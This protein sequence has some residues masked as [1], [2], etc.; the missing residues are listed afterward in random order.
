MTTKKK[1]KNG[2]EKNSVKEKSSSKKN[3]NNNSLKG[4]AEMSNKKENNKVENGVTEGKNQNALREG[5]TP[6][7][8]D[9]EHMHLKYIQ[10]S[11]DMV[12]VYLA[13]SDDK[14][15]LLKDQNLSKAMK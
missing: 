6:E 15:D 5:V 3:I 8:Q 4:E 1:D 9:Q 2:I 13:V 7:P 11:P 12:D 10:H 14:G